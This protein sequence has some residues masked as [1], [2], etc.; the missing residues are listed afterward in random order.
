[1]VMQLIPNVRESPLVGG[2]LAI[3]QSFMWSERGKG[4]DGGEEDNGK[5]S[6]KE[7]SE[8]PKRDPFS[9]KIFQDSGQTNN[10]GEEWEEVQDDPNDPFPKLYNMAD[11]TFVKDG[12][13]YR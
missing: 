10:D 12:R 5:N 6:D 13:K 8:P 7:N 2:L 9:S 1:M 11:Q 4:K 3:F